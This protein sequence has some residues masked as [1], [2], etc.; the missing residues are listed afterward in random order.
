MTAKETGFRGF[1]AP[2]WQEVSSLWSGAEF[3]FLEQPVYADGEDSPSAA[4]HD[5]TSAASDSAMEAGMYGH[6][7]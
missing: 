2:I 5:A 4:F 3:A 6:C 7:C 1:L